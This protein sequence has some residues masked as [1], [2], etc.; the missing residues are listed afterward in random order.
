MKLLIVD[1]FYG[2]Y[3]QRLYADGAL[4]AQPWAQQHR[5]HF[6]GGFGTGDAYS[7]GLG[8]LGV[9]AIEIVANSA[10]L[11][12][13]WA[14]EHRPE[15][16]Q[17]QDPGQQLLAILEAQIRWWQPTVLYVQDINWLTAAFLKH[18]KPLLQLVV[19][20]NACPLAPN[21]DLRPYDLLLTSLPHYVGRFRKEGVDA[22]YFPIGFDQRLLQRHN[23]KGPRPHPLTFV[24]GLGGYHSQGTQMLEAI[25]QKLPLQVWGYG[26]QQLPAGSTLKQRWQGE[27]WADDMYGLL[28]NSKITINRHIDIAEN[29]ANN[30]RL[31]EATGMG[32]CLVT[33][34]KDNLASLFDIDREIVTYKTVSEAI[35][36]IKNLLREPAIAKEIAVQGQKR[37][38]LEHSYE[39]RMVHLLKLLK[40]GT[41]QSQVTKSV[42]SEQPAVRKSLE[43]QRALCDACCLTYHTDP[44]LK[45]FQL[46]QNSGADNHF[47][48]EIGGS[49]PNF[50]IKR[51]PFIDRYCALLGKTYSANWD[52]QYL[53]RARL[54]I[55]N[56]YDLLLE[57][58][59][60]LRPS[61]FQGILPTACISIA[62]FE[63]IHQLELSLENLHQLLANNSIVYGFFAPIW[64][65]FDG[66]HLPQIVDDKGV[67]HDFSS[68]TLYPWQHLLES[69][70]RMTESLAKTIDLNTVNSI[71]ESVYNSP[72]I[73]RLFYD[74]Y[75]NIFEASKFKIQSIAPVGNVSIS[76]DLYSRLIDLYPG[77]SNFVSNGIE[78]L[79]QKL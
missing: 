61:H 10:P 60:D 63:H 18:V 66:H 40:E 36:K 32:A 76:S 30:M 67:T 72:Y 39:K 71:V 65:A 6:A 75:I 69:P 22:A 21:L 23:T 4:A 64:S 3:L 55:S 57:D 79:L 44:Y 11:Q 38:L 59:V 46:L 28:A 12:Q 62:A 50:L 78:V 15:L 13:A 54:N 77:K 24:G 9:P 31:Y 48:L 70:N 47:V 20:Q 5:A 26:G 52:T 1:T 2:P 53:Q 56:N 29:Y 42:S 73:N 49:L 17:L 25:A 33:D 74:D 58:L 19:G 51:N 34:Y 45:F 43:Y 68:K 16:L 35:S 41:T 37:T 8:L 14:L 27:A 7:H